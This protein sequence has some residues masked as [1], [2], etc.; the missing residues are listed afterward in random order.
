MQERKKNHWERSAR[1]TRGYSPPHRAPTPLQPF[2]HFILHTPPRHSAPHLVQLSDTSERKMD[3]ALVTAEAP[4]C[5]FRVGLF[6]YVQD[7]GYLCCDT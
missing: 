2:P 4:V 1:N 6:T 3:I 7:T 5:C